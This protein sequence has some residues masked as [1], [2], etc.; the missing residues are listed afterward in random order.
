MKSIIITGMLLLCSCAM[1]AMKEKTIQLPKAS[2]LRESLKK[3][4]FSAFTN[5]TQ[6]HNILSG[7]KFTLGR[8]WVE[9]DLALTQYAKE[10]PSFNITTGRQTLF[11]IILKKYPEALKDLQQFDKNLHLLEKMYQK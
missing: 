9:I 4:T 10:V 3:V 5:K 2:V 1:Q 8:I 11:D 7:E 6:I